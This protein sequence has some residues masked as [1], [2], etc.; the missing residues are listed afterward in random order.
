MND[1]ISNCKIKNGKFYSVYL[2]P[3]RNTGLDEFSNTS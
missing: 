1:I 3:T 2:L